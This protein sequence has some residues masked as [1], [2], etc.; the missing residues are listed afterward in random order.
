MRIRGAVLSGLVLAAA[1]PATAIGGVV[2]HDETNV[3]R[4]VGSD[5]SESL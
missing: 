4:Y 1:C 3:T 2:S 5:S